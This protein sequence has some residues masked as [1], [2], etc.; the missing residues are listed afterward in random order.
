MGSD[1]HVLLKHI[2][3]LPSPP[4]TNNVHILSGEDYR[5]ALINR[6]RGIKSADEFT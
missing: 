4:P 1:L 3:K 2:D 6:L 5:K